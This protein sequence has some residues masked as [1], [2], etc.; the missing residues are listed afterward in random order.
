[1]KVKCN[2]RSKQFIVAIIVVLLLY[3]I[4]SNL[5]CRPIISGDTLVKLQSGILEKRE[6]ITEFDV[7]EGIKYIGAFAFYGCTNLK[8][9]TLPD[10]VKII[11]EKA[12]CNCISLEEIILPNSLERI[13]NGAF[14]NCKSLKNIKLPEKMIIIE[15][16]TFSGCTLLENIDLPQKL[17][18]IKTSAF[19]DCKSLRKLVLPN[20]IKSIENYAFKNC[21]SLEEIKAPEN[22]KSIGE[23][24]FEGTAFLT[25][26]QTEEDGGIYWGRVLLK[27]TLLKESVKIKKFTKVIAAK[28]FRDNKTIKNIELPEGLL[29]I[30]NTAFAYCESLEDINLPTSIE[31]VGLDIFEG[32][33]YLKKLQVDE[34]GCKYSEN[35]LLEY[36]TKGID[37]IKI[38]E[39]TRIIA[40][41][42]FYKAE[43]I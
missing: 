39:N 1:M 6:D 32:T 41:N 37:K 24:I 3:L 42:V 2:P 11:R 14:L 16:N 12:F 19:E 18:E 40:G 29:E 26:A 15:G 23:D 28:A 43:D 31:K 35:I 36:K 30:G 25:Q 9:V 27:Y 21:S 17:T 8:N 34:Y 20:S 5:K 13:E 10:T 22:I 4:I 7:P 38:R 33:K